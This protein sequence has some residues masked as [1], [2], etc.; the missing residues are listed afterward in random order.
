MIVAMEPTT[1]AT[2]HRPPALWLMA[3]RDFAL[4]L[5]ALSLW[6]A[7]DAWYLVTDGA[8]V[9][10]VLSVPVAVLAALLVTALVHEWGHYT[11]ARLAG[12]HAPLAP[13]R[14]VALFNFDLERSSAAQFQWMSL[15]GNISPWLLLAL[16]GVAVGVATPGRFMLLAAVLGFTLFAHLTE[17]PIIWRSLRG[18]AAAQAFGRLG[19]ALLVRNGIIGGV[20]ALALVLT[21]AR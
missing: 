16:L 8:L 6:A 10:A 21:A 12:A 2:A 15:G 5:A 20:L 9:A 19:P 11:F 1:A 18:M 4:S 17:A 3:L 13:A 7:T 14:S